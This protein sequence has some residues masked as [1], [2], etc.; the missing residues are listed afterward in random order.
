MGV[1]SLIALLSL[2]SVFAFAGCSKDAQKVAPE[3]RGKRGENCLARND[4]EAGLACLNGTCAKNEFNIEV[5][6]KVC[7]RI[8]C[9]ADEDCC[10]DKKTEAP[11]KCKGRE[12]ICNQPSLPGCVATTC[13]DDSSCMG[14]GSCRGTCVGGT[15]SGSACLTV[16]DC[17]PTPNTCVLFEGLTYGSCSQTGATC[18]SSGG[19]TYPPCAVGS[20]SCSSKSCKCQ[21]P[22]YMPSSEICSDPDCEDICI[23]RCSDTKQCVQDT[24]C[25]V[26]TDCAKVGLP[27]CDGGRCVECTTSKDCDEDNDETCVDGMCN[28][29]CEHN[30]ECGLFHACEDGECKYVG[31][32]SDRECI[33]A[34]ARGTET[35][36]TGDVSSA[37]SSGGDD[38]RLYKCLEN[39]GTPKIKTCKIPCENDGS[40]GQFQVCDSGYCKFVGCENDEDCRVYLG[41]A[42]QQ[43]SEAKPYLARAQCIDPSKATTADK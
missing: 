12:T 17:P 7:E 1:R 9:E 27:T 23:L 8:E 25:K 40:C 20:T 4:C 18:G 35:P 29:P 39:E 3:T 14:G 33:L 26:D 30:E 37:V 16:A 36:N 21:N 31:C 5:T 15:M 34:A 41:I 13:I 43:V 28:K 11:A 42:N 24:S 6:A 10:G 22:D 2:T 32:T 38:P 19:T